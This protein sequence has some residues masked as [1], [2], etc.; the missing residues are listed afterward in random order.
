MN[1]RSFRLVFRLGMMLAGLAHLGTAQAQVTG[2]LGSDVTTYFGSQADS[3]QMSNPAGLNPWTPVGNNPPAF[4]AS[5]PQLPN[6]PGPP[7]GNVAP[8]NVTP[9]AP[10]PSSSSYNDGY[11]D[12]AASTILGLVAG[13]SLTA[14]AAMVD[15]LGS[16]GM[17]LTET[18]GQYAY[19]QVNFDIDFSVSN[20]VNTITGTTGT[21]GGV[22][23][24]TY[25]V[26]G[27]VGTGVGAFAAFGGQLNFWDATTNTSLGAP[28][29]FNYFNNVGGAFGGTATG[30][31]FVAAVPSP[32]VLRITGDFFV[33]GDPSSIQVQS[34]PE[35]S[36]LLLFAL[37]SLGLSA[38][39]RRRRGADA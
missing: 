18:V 33:I 17:T 31:T 22:V 20:I 15:L 30:S 38:L 10:I 7:A 19:E 39:G 13:P 28:L 9:F 26:S 5:I 29:T 34:V 23:T 21:I 36:T 11:G 27:L 24:D 3:Y 12:T 32:D 25:A 14:Q 6:V 35:P 2:T 4:Y 8:S 1:A 37:G 16:S